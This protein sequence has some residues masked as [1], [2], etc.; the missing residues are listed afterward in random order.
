L[1]KPV[2]YTELAFSIGLLLLALGTAL[3]SAGGF[4]VSMVVAPAYILH[5]KLS[6]SLPF[7][8]FGMAEYVLQAIVLIMMMCALRQAK[9]SYLFTVVTA[10]VYG[11]L[12]DGAMA[13]TSLLPQNVFGL[14]ILSYGFG[15]LLCALAISFLLRG[16]LPP[17]AY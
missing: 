8:S 15:D 9:V 3:M 13:L 2:V 16:Y 7:F 10:V 1:K 11:F 6:Q 4:G 17:A 5:L 12:L 14:Q